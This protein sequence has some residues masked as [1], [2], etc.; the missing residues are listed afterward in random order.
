MIMK[1]ADCGLAFESRIVSTNRKNRATQ[2]CSRDTDFAAKTVQ[3]Y[4]STHNRRSAIRRGRGRRE[5]QSGEG[6]P[7]HQLE[8]ECFPNHCHWM[9]WT[10]AEGN[11]NAASRPRTPQPC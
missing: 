2:T 7:P 5:R 10:R 3:K 11:E 8:C 9:S 1:R 6:Y 4:V